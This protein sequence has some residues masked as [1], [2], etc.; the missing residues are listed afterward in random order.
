MG[1][2]PC[3]V[4]PNDQTWAYE[5]SRSHISD[6]ILVPNRVYPCSVVVDPCHGCNLMT[7]VEH[8]MTSNM[9]LGP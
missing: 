9:S 8:D 6:S 3:G 4:R 7:S 2:I 5:V 1:L